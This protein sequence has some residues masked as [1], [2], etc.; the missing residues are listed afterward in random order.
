MF[1][2]F[3]DAACYAIVAAAILGSMWLVKHEERRR[4][5]G[6]IADEHDAIHLRLL[7]EGQSIPD[8]P[9]IENHLD[10][11]CLWTTCWIGVHPAWLLLLRLVSTVVLLGLLCWDI[12]RWNWLIF[13]Y[14]TEWTFTLVIAYFTLGT[15]ISAHGCWNLKTSNQTPNSE[16]NLYTTAGLWGYTMQIMYQICAGGVMLT[17]IVFWGIIVPILRTGHFTLDPLM[18]CIHSFNILFI[19][20]ETCLNNMP[21]PLF[22]MSYFVMWSCAYVIFQWILHYCGFSWW[23]YPFLDLTIPLAPLW[24]LMMALT[25]IPSYA[26]YYGIVKGKL[27]FFPKMF[28]NIYRKN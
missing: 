14:Y 11:S 28:P 21:F 19:L 10:Y 6:V 18:G 27:I 20:L 16:Q 2:T 7:L 5:P 17:D 15:F 9:R 13:I 8:L 24:Y 4:R 25:H 22:R 26:L 3:S 12:K 23:P 1:I